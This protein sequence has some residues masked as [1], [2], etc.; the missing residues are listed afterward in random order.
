MSEKK[1]SVTSDLIFLQFS[2]HQVAVIL[3]VKLIIIPYLQ[4]Y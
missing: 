4:N 2:F 3:T 1:S